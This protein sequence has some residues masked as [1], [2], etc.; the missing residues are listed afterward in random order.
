MIQEAQ[1]AGVY[2]GD[3]AEQK[4]GEVGKSRNVVDS[5]FRPQLKPNACV[6]EVGPGTGMFAFKILEYIP[7]GTL[8]LY[9]VDPYWQNY[10]KSRLHNDPRVSIYQASG[11]SYDEISDGSVDLY[12][13]NGVFEYT[14]QLVMYRNLMEGIRVTRSGGTLAFDF[15]DSDELDILEFIGSILLPSLVFGQCIPDRS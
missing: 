2:I 9:E 14:D 4:W 8:H 5:L 7:Q 11:F 12:C 1:Q 13:A 15:F 3:Y 10:L 6:L